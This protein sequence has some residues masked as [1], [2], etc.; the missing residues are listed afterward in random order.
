MAALH[1]WCTVRRV[2]GAPAIHANAT[3]YV[4]EWRSTRY[5]GPFPLDEG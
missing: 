5:D 4:M 1:A 2:E 3:G